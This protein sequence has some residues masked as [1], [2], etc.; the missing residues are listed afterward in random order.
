MSS[1]H[2]QL[3]VESL[4]MAVPQ[5]LDRLDEAGM[6]ARHFMA[7]KC[8][9]AIVLHGYDPKQDTSPEVGEHCGQRFLDHPQYCMRKQRS[10]AAARKNAQDLDTTNGQL[11]KYNRVCI[12]RETPSRNRYNFGEYSSTSWPA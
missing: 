12:E 1:S 11:H 2:D 6:P 5:C 7:T 3:Q 8:A 4:A 9:N 10:Q